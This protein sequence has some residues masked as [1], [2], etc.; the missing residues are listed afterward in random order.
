MEI[1]EGL[2][3]LRFLE[4][5]L[6]TSIVELEPLDWDAV[7]LNNPSDVQVIERVLVERGIA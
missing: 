3:Q 4:L 2:E 5:G 6:P 7:E 1:L